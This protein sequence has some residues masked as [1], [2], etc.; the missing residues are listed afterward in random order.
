MINFHGL[1]RG[2]TQMSG[3]IGLADEQHVAR[4]CR[5]GLVPEIIELQGQLDFGLFQQRHDRL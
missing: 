3:N 4:L 1:S 5:S 2:D